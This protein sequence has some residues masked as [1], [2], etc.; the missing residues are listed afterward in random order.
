MAGPLP[1][2]V[3]PP[4][5]DVPMVDLKTGAVTAIWRLFFASLVAKPSAISLV[6]I[7]GGSPFSYQ[8][9][10]AGHL[11]IVG[12]TV[13]NVQLTRARVTIS[14]GLG[15]QFYPMGLGD[16]IEITYS[17]PPDVYFVPN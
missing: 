7:T 3:Q 8:P 12:G 2:I 9:N 16:V 17:A 15:S 5:T 13:S 11:L 4:G 1:T 14:L 6:T 10:I